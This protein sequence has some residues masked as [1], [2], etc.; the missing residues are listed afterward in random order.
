MYLHTHKNND[1]ESWVLHFSPKE[2]EAIVNAVVGAL[3][4]YPDSTSYELT[5]GTVEDLADE[6]EKVVIEVPLWEGQ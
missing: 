4:D 2:A 5:L 6:S 3:N 1:T